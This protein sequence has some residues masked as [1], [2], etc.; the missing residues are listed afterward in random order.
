MIKLWDSSQGKLHYEDQSPFYS[1]P[2]I[3]ADFINGSRGKQRYGES[4]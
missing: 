3:L 2:A 1:I 4:E